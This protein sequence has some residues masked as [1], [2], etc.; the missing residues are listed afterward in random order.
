MD[1]SGVWEVVKNSAQAVGLDPSTVWTHCLRKTY[2]KILN[3]ESSR[4]LDDD[5]REALMGHKL[6]GSRGSY[7]DYH[8]TDEVREKYLQIDWSR[9][10]GNTKLKALEE[11]NE[12]LEQELDEVHR[13]ITA[14]NSGVEERLKTM[15]KSLATAESLFFNMVGYMASAKLKKLPDT[16]IKA[17]QSQTRRMLAERVATPSKR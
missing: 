6:P 11:K 14:K 15:Q 16:E 7:F 13:Q 8:D 1:T 2:R 9:N 3:S 4:D 10:G 12:Q 5:T 17:L